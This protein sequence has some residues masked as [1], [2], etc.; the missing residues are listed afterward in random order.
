MM[1]RLV[2]EQIATRTADNHE[3]DASDEED[4]QRDQ[5]NNRRGRELAKNRGRSCAAQVENNIATG[6]YDWDAV[7]SRQYL[8]ATQ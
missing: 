5:A 1:T 8:N 7:S 2:G 3:A 4:S 6:Q